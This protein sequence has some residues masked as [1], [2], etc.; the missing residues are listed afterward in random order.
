[1]ILVYIHLLRKSLLEAEKWSPRVFADKLV[2]A[3]PLCSAAGFPLI[4]ITWA[5]TAFFFKDTEWNVPLLIAD[6]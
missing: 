4:P 2:V 3:C 5:L 1:V 6:V